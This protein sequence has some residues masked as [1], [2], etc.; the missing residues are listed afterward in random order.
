MNQ[1]ILEFFEQNVKAYLSELV[2]ICEVEYRYNEQIRFSREIGDTAFVLQIAVSMKEYKYVSLTNILVPP[3]MKGKGVSIDI[4]GMLV[5]LCNE[6]GFDLFVTEIANDEWKESLIRHGG[7]EDTDGDVQI[8]KNLWVKQNKSKNL[9]FVE[10]QDELIEVSEIDD[11]MKL[12]EACIL[13][14]AMIYKSWGSEVKVK[15]SKGY[16]QEI[17]AEKGEETYGVKIFYRVVIHLMN[18]K[19]QNK[20]EEHL[21]ENQF[22]GMGF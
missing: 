8:I 7:R 21:K 1:D 11:Y 18:L 20:L 4:I 6:K 16:I 13:D 19:I 22:V 15:G 14:V 10:Y 2:G 12:K 5:R 3:S 9:K 17:W